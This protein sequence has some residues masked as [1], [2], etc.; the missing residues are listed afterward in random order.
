MHEDRY[1]S[2][3]TRQYALKVWSDSVA[4]SSLVSPRG[5]HCIC[6]TRKPDDTLKLAICSA[7]IRY[8]IPLR[9]LLSVGAGNPHTTGHTST[10]GGNSPGGVKG[11]PGKQR[12]CTYRTYADS[13]FSGELLLGNLSLN[14]R[15]ISLR[16]EAIQ[17]FQAKW[18]H[19]LR[20]SL[21]LRC[22]CRLN[23]RYATIVKS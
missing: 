16:R 5:L 13:S 1:F 21:D 12:S 20:L 2:C 23:I 15:I 6:A 22:I 3:A 7:V 14:P 9:E 10:G 11:I 18:G 17:P 4:V 19:V 8:A